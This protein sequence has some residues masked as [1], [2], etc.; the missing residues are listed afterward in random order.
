MYKLIQKTINNYIYNDPYFQF[1]D[2][3]RLTSQLP[4]LVASYEVPFPQWSHLDFC[5]AIDADTLLYAEIL[6]NMEEIRKT[7]PEWNSD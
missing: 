2:V 7:V 5:W 6:K 3:V 4:N 1:Q